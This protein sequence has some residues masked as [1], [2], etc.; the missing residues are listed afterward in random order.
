MSEDTINYSKQR[1][2]QEANYKP[3]DNFKGITEQTR[4]D[5]MDALTIAEFFTLAANTP[6]VSKAEKERLV[7][8][9]SRFN[10][11]YNKLNN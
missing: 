2:D 4:N 8:Q 6:V 10:E 1:R 7:N 9:A 3:V 5:L 11:I